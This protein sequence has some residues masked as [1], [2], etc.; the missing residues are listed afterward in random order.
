LAKG[1]EFEDLPPEVRLAIGLRDAVTNPLSEAIIRIDFTWDIARGNLNDMERALRPWEEGD[2]LSIQQDAARAH[3]YHRLVL[4]LFHN[5]LGSAVSAVWHA[6]R[7]VSR[8][9]RTAV[10]D[11]Q[12]DLYVS[13]SKRRDSLRG[14]QNY[15]VLNCLRHY[16]VHT[17]HHL[18]V[19]VLRGVEGRE[20]LAAS[21]CFDMS[22][23]S[24]Y[25][26][27][28]TRGRSQDDQDLQRIIKALPEQPEIRQILH[29]YFGEVESLL[30]WL[31][32]TLI[33]L[34]MA[35]NARPLEAW[36]SSTM[37]VAEQ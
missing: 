32:Q 27:E 17:G 36:T 11:F 33:D 10:K 25:L 22:V 19:L 24:T 6:E 13:F 3:Q 14:S 34:R 12:P 5:F 7:I 8:L 9:M 16:A 15:R 29:N 30:R 18:T 26:K 31:R 21:V 28:N 1:V 35:A 23:V 2:W 4:R 20:N 37:E